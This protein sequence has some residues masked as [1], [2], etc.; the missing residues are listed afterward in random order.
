MFCTCKKGPEHFSVPLK[1]SKCCGLAP[2]D[3]HRTQAMPQREAE[4]S[5]FQGPTFEVTQPPLL[6]LHDPPITFLW[7]GAL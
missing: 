2:V 5:Y 4:L 3:M 7:F 6:F 1:S